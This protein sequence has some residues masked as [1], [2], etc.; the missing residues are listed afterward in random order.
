MLLPCLL[1][2]VRLFPARRPERA[3]CAGWGAGWSSRWEM[4]PA[5]ALPGQMVK[6]GE[7]L[8]FRSIH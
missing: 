8:P 6:M 4:L 3:C 1:W 5:R 2:P 7:L